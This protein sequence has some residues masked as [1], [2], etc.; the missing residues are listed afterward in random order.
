MMNLKYQVVLILHQIIQDYMEYII[1]KHEALKKIRPTYICINRINNILVFQIKNR[2]K[3]QLQTP[4]TLKLF[5]STNIQN[6][7]RRKNTKS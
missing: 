5:G 2:Y 7:K 3:L 6:K 4:E 1:K